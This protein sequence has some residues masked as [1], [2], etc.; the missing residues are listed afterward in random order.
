MCCR[1]LVPFFLFLALVSSSVWAVVY[2]SLEE[3]ELEAL[4]QGSS[5]NQQGSSAVGRGCDFIVV[6]AGTAGSVLASRLSENREWRVLVVEAGPDNEGIENLQIP[7]FWNRL[8]K[9]YDWNYST[10]PQAGLDGRSVEYRRGWVVGG[11]SSVSELLILPVM[12]RLYQYTSGLRAVKRHTTEA[13]WDKMPQNQQKKNPQHR[14]SNPRPHQTSRG[15]KVSRILDARNP[16]QKNPSPNRP[17]NQHACGYTRGAKDDYDLWAR[18]TKDKRWSWEAMWPYLLRNENWTLPIGG[19]DP[20]GQ[21]DP[22]YHDTKG[23]VRVALAWDGP[24]AHDLWAL[25][26]VTSKEMKVNEDFRFN[27]D[28]NDGSPRGVG[29]NQFTAGGGECSSA[30]TA[31]LP[32]HVRERPNLTILLNT[33]VLRVLPSREGESGQLDV[34]S[35]ELAPMIAR[36]GGRSSSGTLSRALQALASDLS[37]AVVTPNST[38]TVTASKELILS[39]RAINCPHI[40]LL[41]G[42]GNRTELE[43]VG[44]DVVHDLPGVGKGMSDH[45]NVVVRWRANVSA[46]K[47]KIP[48]PSSR[49]L[50]RDFSHFVWKDPYSPT[51]DAHY[52]RSPTALVTPCEVQPCPH[53]LERPVSH[54]VLFRLRTAGYVVELCGE[55]NHSLVANENFRPSF[56]DTQRQLAATSPL[57]ASLAPPPPLDSAGSRTASPARTVVPLPSTLPLDAVASSSVQNTES[58]AP[59]NTSSPPTTDNEHDASFVTTEGEPLNDN[60]SPI[61]ATPASPLH[62]VSIP[63]AGTPS[64]VEMTNAQELQ[65]LRNQQTAQAQVLEQLLKQ[66]TEKAGASR[67]PIKEPEPFKGQMNDAR[68]FLRFF[69]NWASNQRQPL[70]DTAGKRNDRAWISS[71]LSFMQGDAAN[72]AS[73]FLQQIV[74]HDAAEEKD[75]A[76][77]PWPFNGS[78]PE[79]TTQFNA[80]F[81]PADDKEA[82]QQELDNLAQGRSSVAQFAAK[83]QE[84]FARTGLS[85]EDGMSK[86][87]RK[88]N[89]DDKLWLAMA[90]MVKKPTTL[91]ELVNTCI[92]NEFVMRNAGVDSPVP[93]ARRPRLPRP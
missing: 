84:I 78:W 27:L 45:V 65:D 2:H 83:F 72:W 66:L 9:R 82:A 61:N 32:T 37:S 56:N 15:L 93:L 75:K 77:K 11:S 91:Q 22:R 70:Q 53:R 28:M 3:F 68:R 26:A 35:V 51:R 79:F 10:T 16:A 29:W 30:A 60:H 76:S 31:Y 74:D 40:L 46:E 81:Q 89:R 59:S 71:A 5:G 42:I 87:K 50:C 6:G 86:F 64:D 41:S 12:G 23:N 85:E 47:V 80:R 25:E 49:L 44:V 33:L 88:L 58:R 39:A 57:P 19:R 69:T 73:R 90:S 14:E 7:A 4:E 67:S 20:A 43:D 36:S 13:C 34:R 92:S 54:T 24:N 62:P 18:I 55:E 38:R 63:P 48:S 52:A 21:F 17:R 8:D 1:L